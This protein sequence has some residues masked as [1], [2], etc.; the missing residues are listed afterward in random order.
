MGVFFGIYC[1][2]PFFGMVGFIEYYHVAIFDYPVE[3]VQKIDPCIYIIGI[4]FLP[5]VTLQLGSQANDG[6][7][8]Q[9]SKM[10]ESILPPVMISFILGNHNGDIA[11]VAAI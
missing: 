8:M 7:K 10:I 5:A 2:A 6:D 4:W 1:A 11:P 3:R 9:L